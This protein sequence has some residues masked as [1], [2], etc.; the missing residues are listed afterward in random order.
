VLADARALAAT[1]RTFEDV[2]HR[3]DMAQFWLDRGRGDYAMLSLLAAT[4]ELIESSKPQATTLR[5][6]IDQVIWSLSRTL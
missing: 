3:L 4:D 2:S 1:D 6:E 5:L